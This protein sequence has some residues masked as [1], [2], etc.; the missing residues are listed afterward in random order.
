MWVKREDVPGFT[1]VERLGLRVSVESFEFEDR[2]CKCLGF[3]ESSRSLYEK[4]I[5]L[6]PFWQQSLLH[7]MFF[8]SNIQEFMW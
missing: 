6:K 2:T 4:K 3:G 5:R 1:R 8:T 7:S